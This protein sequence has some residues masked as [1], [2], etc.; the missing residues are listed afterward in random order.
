M[1][2]SKDTET[3]K[4]SPTACIARVDFTLLRECPIHARTRKNINRSRIRYTVIVVMTRPNQCRVAVERY[5]NTKPIRSSRIVRVKFCLLRKRPVSARTRK[6]INGSRIRLHRYRRQDAP[7][8]MPCRRTKIRRYQNYHQQLHRS[9][10][11]FACGVN[12]P[13][14]LERVKIRTQI[15]KQ[16]H[17]YRRLRIAPQSVQCRRTK[18]RRHQTKS[19]AAASL[20]VKFCLLRKRPVSARTRKNTYTDPEADAPLSSSSNAPQSVQCC[21]TKKRRRPNKSRSSS[22]ARVGVYSV[23]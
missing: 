15:Q 19:E 17:R 12:V 9:R 5:G 8:S 22:I 11:G 6:N 2:P 14:A 3:P 16:M 20:R 7:Q 10:E 4:L 13:S 23:A 21:R 18:I 1:L